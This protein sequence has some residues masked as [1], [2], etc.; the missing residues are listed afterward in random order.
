MSRTGKTRIPI[1][2]WFTIEKVDLSSGI[3]AITDVKILARYFIILCR[4]AGT[5][6]FN[7]PSPSRLIGSFDPQ[8]TRRP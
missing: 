6:I 3:P 8:L 4:A 7:P 5:G 1:T 2:S